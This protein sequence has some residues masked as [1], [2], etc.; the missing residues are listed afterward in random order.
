RSGRPYATPVLAA[1]VADGFAIPLPFGTDTDWCLNLLAAGRFT[2]RW[3]GRDYALE[4]P[5]VLDAPAALRLLGLRR[6]V[7]ARHGGPTPGHA[8]E[9]FRRLAQAGGPPHVWRISPRAGGD[10]KALCVVPVESA[11]AVAAHPARFTDICQA[12]PPVEVV[13]GRWRPRTAPPAHHRTGPRRSRTMQPKPNSIYPTPA[14]R[15]RLMALYDAKLAHWPVPFEEFDVPTRYGRAHVVA[16]GAQDAPPLVLVHAAAFPAFMWGRL[17]APLSARYRTYALDTIGDLGKSEVA[18]FHRCPKNGK[19][20]SA[21]LKDVWDRLGL[22]AADVV[23]ASM[24]GWVA[25]N[26]AACA[27]ECVRRLALL[28]P[29]GLPSW[30]QTFVVLFK[31]ATMAIGPSSSKQERFITWVIGDDLLVRREVGDWLVAV[32]ESGAKTRAGNPLPV[33]AARL[34]AIRAP[35]LV[36]LGGRDNLVGNATRAARRAQVH[37]PGVR[38]ELVPEAA[39]ALPIEAADRVAGWLLEFFEPRRPH[40]SA[41]GERYL[42][43]AASDGN[44]PGNPQPPDRELRFGIGPASQAVP[45]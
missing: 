4:E 1:R 2:L 6:Y 41:E 27:P 8:E 30:L 43:V 28:V 29:M 25:M 13:E 15:D 37:L 38:I 32:L 22:G 19:D 36:V 33:P 35:T 26:H 39:H 23:A 17:V 42:V 10:G 40:V 18:D 44:A 34:E 21:W 20:H 5:Q 9:L 7:K 45:R 3:R 16:A 12:T 24:G 14:A 31:M 11:G